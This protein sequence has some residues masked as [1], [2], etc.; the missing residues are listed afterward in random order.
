M[1]KKSARTIFGYDK[2]SVFTSKSMNSRQGDP[3]LRRQ[4]KVPK[5]YL[6]TL[7]TESGGSV[8]SQP[9][10]SQ[11]NRVR[12][13][14]KLEKKVAASVLGSRVAADDPASCQVSF[15][16]ALFGFTLKWL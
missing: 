13:G 9:V 15:P 3:V 4:M 16:I 2:T 10:I 5:D 8:F 1:G 7:A 6:S 11:E 12:I 14:G